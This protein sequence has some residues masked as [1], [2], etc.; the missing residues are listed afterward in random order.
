MTCNCETPGDC[1]C[2]LLFASLNEWEQRVSAVLKA[3]LATSLLFLATFTVSAVMGVALPFTAVSIHPQARMQTFGE[4][5]VTEGEHEALRAQMQ[6]ADA[7]L[8]AG[9][10]VL[11]QRLTDDEKQIAI[12]TQILQSIASTINRT[13]GI[14]IS[15]GIVVCAVQFWLVLAHN[16]RRKNHY[17]RGF[18]EGLRGRQGPVGATGATG[19]QGP[20]GQEFDAE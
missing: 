1:G 11:A 16:A 4:K 6:V 8:V 12:N 2:L 17:S 20:Q 15:F 13:E 18:Y 5:G 19:P 9:Q 7:Q 3:S 10:A 14:G